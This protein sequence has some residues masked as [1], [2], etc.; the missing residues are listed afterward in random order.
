MRQAIEEFV[1]REERRSKL[2]RDT[3]EAWVSYTETG[4]AIEG[5]AVL[6]WLARWGTPDDGP[7]RSS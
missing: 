5:D 3:Y 4:E 1:D 7:L 6:A 2:N